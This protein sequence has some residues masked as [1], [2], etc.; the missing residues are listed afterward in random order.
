M[1]ARVV[2]RGGSL[3]QEKL[4]AA[5]AEME[6]GTVLGTYRVA[7]GGEQVGI[8]PAL[9]Q[10]RRGRPEVLWPPELA[11]EAKLSPYLPWDERT[12]LK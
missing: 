4:R 3:D 7:P 2:E 11:G 10:I 12:L 6:I 1:L 8:R 9:V 5:L